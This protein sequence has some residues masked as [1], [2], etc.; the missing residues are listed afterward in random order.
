MSACESSKGN[1]R[2][3]RGETK[4]LLNHKS[5]DFTDEQCMK[6][7]KEVFELCYFSQRMFINSH[8]NMVL[9]NLFL[10]MHL[11]ILTGHTNV[12]AQKLDRPKLLT[13]GVLKGFIN[14]DTTEDSDFKAINVI[15]KHFKET[16]D[17]LFIPLPVCNVYPFN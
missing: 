4:I 5:F 13:Y 17:A 2:N 6:K 11:L 9:E 14:Q 7:F 10:H 12:E 1:C 8:K 16:M 15:F 3:A